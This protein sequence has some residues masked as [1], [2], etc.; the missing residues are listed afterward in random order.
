MQESGNPQTAAFQKLYKSTG[1]TEGDFGLLIETNRAQVSRKL[2]GYE[3]V[4]DVVLGR[5]L[6]RMGAAAAAS[7]VDGTAA[8]EDWERQRKLRLLAILRNLQASLEIAIEETPKERPSRP[9]L[10][11]AYNASETA[12]G[13]VESQ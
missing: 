8:D 10:E 4:G 7:L 3:P 6:R 9:L 12:L 1:L 11:D 5:V 2:N 13:L